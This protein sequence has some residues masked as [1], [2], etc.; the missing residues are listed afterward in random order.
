MM[1]DTTEAA[2]QAGEV[3]GCGHGRTWGRRG[4]RGGELGRRKAESVEAGPAQVVR[5]GEEGGR[6]AAWGWAWSSQSSSQEDPTLQDHPLSP[7]DSQ[8]HPA[9]ELPL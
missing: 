6:R 1:T 4:W 9:W 2:E 3:Q 5:T 8:T 7:G